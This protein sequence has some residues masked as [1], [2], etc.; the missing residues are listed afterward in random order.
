MIVADALTIGVAFGT[1]RWLVALGHNGVG[2]GP[3]S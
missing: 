2:G 1:N 3:V